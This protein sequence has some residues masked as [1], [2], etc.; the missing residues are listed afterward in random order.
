MGEIQSMEFVAA[1][2]PD[3][4]GE[5]AGHGGD[6]GLGVLASPDELLIPAAESFLRRPGA[7]SGVFRGLGG[8]SL[9][10]PTLTRGEAIGPGTLDQRPTDDAIA[11]LGDASGLTAPALLDS[12]GVIPR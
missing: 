2:V 6:H 4:A 11:G 7:L 9:Q 1:D 3:E 5:F 12:L 10:M 8:L